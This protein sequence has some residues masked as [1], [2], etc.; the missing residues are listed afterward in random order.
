MFTFARKDKAMETGIKNVIEIIVS[1][2][3]TAYS[4][5]SGTLRIFATPAMIALI[6]E[7]AWRSVE[8][9]LEEGQGTVGTALDIKHLS[10]TPLNMKVKCETELVEID[11]RKLKFNANVYDETGLIGS[12]THE[13]FIINVEKFIAKANSKKA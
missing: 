7:T 9:Y 12:G 10:P 3:K 13:R 1:D 8:P 11:G 5:R 4:M 2:D 6:E